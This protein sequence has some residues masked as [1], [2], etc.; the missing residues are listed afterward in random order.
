M[1]FGHSHIHCHDVDNMK[2]FFDKLKGD[3]KNKNNNNNNDN[4]KPRNTS[5]NDPF[6]SFGGGGP[7]T[8][9]FGGQGQSLGGSLPGR[10]ISISLNQPGP[11]GIK[12]CSLHVNLYEYLYVEN[13]TPCSFH[14]FC[15][16][17][18]SLSSS[19]LPHVHLCL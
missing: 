19:F 7:R 9:T 14:F 3:D 8:R 17:L 10:I 16:L 1:W 13:D 4:N 2:A 5:N 15:A 11:L 12:V 6:A 18:F